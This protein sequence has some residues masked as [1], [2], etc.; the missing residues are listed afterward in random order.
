MNMQGLRLDM[1]RLPPARRVLVLAPHPDDEAVGCGGL[2]ARFNRAGVEAMVV[3][4]TDGQHTSSS[5]A[6]ALAEQRR[7][8][9]EIALGVLGV[10][11]TIRW[12]LV[13][14]KVATSD[15]PVGKLQ[16]LVHSFGIELLLVPHLG[17]SHP[18]HQAVARL[19][20]RLNSA[21]LNLTIMTYEIWTPLDPHRVV[22]VSA[23]ME[24]KLQAI[25]AYASQ[26]ERY[27]LERL[28]LGL[29]QYRAAWSQMRW[30]FAECYGCF[31]LPQYQ[32]LCNA[33]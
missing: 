17:E 10:R 11:H 3:F 8:E 19:P 6:K 16:M 15:L 12:G 33:H 22:N 7:A 28:A 1:F 4:V 2:M 24:I 14:G 5:R 25:R 29:G 30:R 18:D 13:D 21:E 23:E 27:H 20:A 31:T 32:E 26:C 9:S